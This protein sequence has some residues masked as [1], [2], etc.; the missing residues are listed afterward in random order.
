M[1]IPSN[2]VFD[3]LKD[4]SKISQ[5]NSKFNKL[6]GKAKYRLI[7]NAMEEGN[8]N[9]SELINAIIDDI[10]QHKMP[11]NPKYELTK[12]YKDKEFINDLSNEDVRKYW[13]EEAD[14]ILKQDEL[15]RPI[16]SNEYYDTFPNVAFKHQ[17]NEMDLLQYLDYRTN[18]DAIFDVP[19]E[20]TKN[21]NENRILDLF[22]EEFSPPSKVRSK[23]D[24]PHAVA[25][26]QQRLNIH[27]KELDWL[28]RN[29][30]YK[31]RS[32]YAQELDKIL[33]LRINNREMPASK[34][35]WDQIKQIA[36]SNA[37]EKKR[38]T[39]IDELM[40]AMVN[41]YVKY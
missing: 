3:Y 36:Y 17:P 27:E 6:S 16:E 34:D 26:A 21:K 32:R 8:I 20:P 1:T 9:Q 7:N 28:K 19:V 33:E 5:P 25:E 24:D 2:I 18:Q 39:P 10:Q 38:A 15:N 23:M 12:T 14:A 40:Q 11:K 4:L 13:E 22:D 37:Y 41:K 30:N 31:P 35:E 29:K